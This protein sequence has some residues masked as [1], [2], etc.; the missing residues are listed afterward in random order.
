MP[1]YID[2]GLLLDFYVGIWVWR[3]LRRLGEVVG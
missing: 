2:L 3:Y 1:K